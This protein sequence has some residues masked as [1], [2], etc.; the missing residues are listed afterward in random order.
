MLHQADPWRQHRVLKRVGSISILILFLIMAF[1]L[2]GQINLRSRGFHLF[3]YGCILFG[4]VI[5]TVTHEARCP[6]CGQRFYAK[7]ADTQPI[8]A[9]GDF[10][11]SPSVTSALGGLPKRD[12]PGS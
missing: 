9:N 4:L 7:G 11:T 2:F 12:F 5:L 10:G 3:I 6:R 1:V 8:P